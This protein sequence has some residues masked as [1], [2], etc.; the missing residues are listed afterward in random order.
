MKQ[1]LKSISPFNNREAM[2][3]S[4]F[5]IKKILAFFLCYIVGSFVAEGA[6]ILLHFAAGKNVFAGEMFD[7]QTITL[8]KYYGF[9]IMAGAALLYWKIIEKKPLIKMGITKEFSSYFIGVMMSAVLLAVSVV[10]IIMVGGFVY[11]GMYKS[12][13]IL[14]VFLL[15]GG[16]MIQG[17]TEEVLCRGIVLHTLK[18]KAPVGMAIAISTV[19]FV[20]PHLSSLFAGD[21]V[22]GIIGIVN[23]IL[24][25]IIFSLLTISSGNIWTACGLHSFW[26][27]ILYCVLGLNLSGNDEKVTALFNIRSTGNTIWNGGEYGVEAS[28]I[29]AAVLFVA[30]VCLAVFCGCRSSREMARE[31]R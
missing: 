31:K 18:E 8:I 30:A 23:L 19:L 12:V 29:T 1:L 9:I 15:T 13:D 2:P 25:S 14:T 3:T 20:A 24:I 4:L 11:R 17:A 7:L 22:Y 26:N 21:L 27:A 28:I 5:I 10:A 6:V 16:F